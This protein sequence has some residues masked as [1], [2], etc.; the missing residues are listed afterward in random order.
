MISRREECLPTTGDAPLRIYSQCFYQYEDFASLSR[1]WEF[2][3]YQNTH[4]VAIG[5]KGRKSNINTRIR[6]NCK[7]GDE[8]RIIDRMK[9]RN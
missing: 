7:N 9:W 6:N 2:I 5:G 3:G 8:V 1:N 4:I